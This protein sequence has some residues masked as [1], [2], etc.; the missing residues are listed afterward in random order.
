VGCAERRRYILCGENE[1]AV[2]TYLKGNETQSWG[3]EFLVNSW[4]HINE[5]LASSKIIC[6]S[7]VTELIY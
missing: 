7:V 5:E 4:L 2:C 1:S 3:E 6:C